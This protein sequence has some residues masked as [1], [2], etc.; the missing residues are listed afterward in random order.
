MISKIKSYIEN[1]KNISKALN[2]LNNFSYIQEDLEDNIDLYFANPCEG[3]GVIKIN[4]IYDR[5]NKI[6]SGLR[7]NCNFIEFNKDKDLKS[8]FINLLLIK[9]VENNKI[10][11]KSK[12]SDGENVDIRIS[13]KEENIIKQALIANKLKGF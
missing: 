8:F 4:Y 2:N 5:K 7:N 9:K 10:I 13:K 3:S 11:L 6:L 12:Y 1:K